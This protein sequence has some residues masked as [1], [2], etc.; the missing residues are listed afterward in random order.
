MKAFKIHNSIVED[1]K[2]YLNSFT[3]IKDKKIR[4]KVDEAFKKGTFLPEA[5]I[6]FNPSFKIGSSLNDLQNEGVVHSDLQKIFGSYRLY[7]HQVEAIRKGV[8][9][10][11]F[12]VTSGTGS[13]KSLTFLA[14]IFNKILKEGIKAG[15]KA[16]IVYPMNALINS[17]EEEIKKYKI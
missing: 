2:S 10:E 9:G 11:S 15:T 5:L 3:L 14:T 13:G 4:E 1:Y 8:N 12:V 7:H 6:Q 16:I 17:Q